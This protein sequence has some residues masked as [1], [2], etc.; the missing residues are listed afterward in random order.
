MLLRTMPRARFIPV[1]SA[2]H[3][4]NIEQPGVVVPAVVKFLGD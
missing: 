2:G 1:D 3:L 4:S